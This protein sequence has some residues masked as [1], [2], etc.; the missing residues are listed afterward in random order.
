[1]NEIFCCFDGN[2]NLCRPR[3]TYNC[4]ESN[5]DNNNYN[6]CFNY[7]LEKKKISNVLFYY[8]PYCNNFENIFIKENDDYIIICNNENNRIINAY[9]IKGNNINDIKYNKFRF[10]EC[11]D[12]YNISLIYNNSNKQYDIITDCYDNN[13]I[14]NIIYISSVFTDNIEESFN[15]H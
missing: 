5:N 9:K 3:Q 1:M 11:N 4:I 6:Q 7:N 13:E 2:Y 12:I 15:I 10:S 8:Y 14:W